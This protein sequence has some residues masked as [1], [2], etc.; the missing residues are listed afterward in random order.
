MEEITRK[1]YRREGWV[2]REGGREGVLVQK[3]SATVDIGEAGTDD[4][5]HLML[6]FSS[7]LREQVT[8]TVVCW[9]QPTG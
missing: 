7:C 5:R 3:T 9:P 4:T 2:M 8:A 1:Y 6:M